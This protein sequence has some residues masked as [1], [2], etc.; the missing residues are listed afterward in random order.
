[1]NNLQFSGKIYKYRSWQNSC[2]KN[3]LLYNE[4]YFASPKDFNDPFDCRIPP[5]Y[6][7]LSE[8]EREQYF[9]DFIKDRLDE[10][11]PG[12]EKIISSF[13]KSSTI[14]LNFRKR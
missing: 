4:L 1:M 8:E 12:Y 13:R 10:N 14:K 2:H 5:N 6:L 3:L 11:Q 7:D 9:N